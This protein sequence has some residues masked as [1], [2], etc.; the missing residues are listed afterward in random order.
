[1]QDLIKRYFW[2]LGAVTVVLCAVFLPT[3]FLN[4]L[5]GAFYHQFA[6]T[7]AGATVSNGIAISTTDSLGRYQLFAPPGV[8]TMT[9]SI[10]GYATLAIWCTCGWTKPIRSAPWLPVESLLG[11]TAAKIPIRSR[12]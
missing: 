10:N 2:L 8:Y 5:S 11:K 3:L 7:I 12:P 1:M 4:G 6:V 9:V